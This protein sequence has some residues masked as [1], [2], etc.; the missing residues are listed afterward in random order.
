MEST[1]T[2]NSTVAKILNASPKLIEYN[3]LRI[4]EKEETP[5]WTYCMYI[6][7]MVLCDDGCVLD[8]VLF[9]IS[10]LLANNDKPL[11]VP[12][13]KYDKLRDELFRTGDTRFVK[14]DRS[15]LPISVTF[16]VYAS[17][18]SSS[19]LF[20]D[21]STCE[22]RLSD[23]NTL[24]IVGTSGARFISIEQHGARIPEALKHEAMQLSESHFQQIASHL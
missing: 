11:Q 8:T 17:K 24:T 9:A 6:D 1:Q 5:K 12:D 23:E 22:M 19:V 10:K 3:A 4:G 18:H 14:I 16:S 20:L 15:S 21:P 13:M 2:L 7:I